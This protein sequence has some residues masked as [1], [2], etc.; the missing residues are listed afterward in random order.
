MT[1]GRG[2]RGA[3]LL[4]TGEP[5]DG[6]WRS[7]PRLH[8]P[9]AQPCLGAS[10]APPSTC[11][12]DDRFD[13]PPTHE[14]GYCPGDQAGARPDDRAG[15]P[16]DRRRSPVSRRW[17]LREH[18]S[19]AT[20]TYSRAGSRLEQQPGQRLRDCSVTDGAVRRGGRRTLATC[21]GRHS[22]RRRLVR[23][24]EGELCGEGGLRLDRSAGAGLGRPNPAGGWFAG[25]AQE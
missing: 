23:Q 2:R 16:A 6:G 15:G 4:L 25:L 9:A 1:A 19:S 17:F 20:P 24:S 14:A 21:P 13:P 3:V 22:S 5:E 10:S 11:L 12:A 7:R 18:W 8:D